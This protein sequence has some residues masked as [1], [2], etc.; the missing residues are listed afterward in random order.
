MRLSVAFGLMLLLVEPFVFGQP[1]D[2]L[3]KG[4]VAERSI[5]ASTSVESF[6]PVGNLRIWQFFAKQTTFGQLTSTVTGRR[7][8]DGGPALIVRESLQID[9]AKIGGETQEVVAGESYVTPLGHFAGCDLKIGP[10]ESAERLVMTRSEEDLT[11]FYTRGGQENEISQPWRKENFFWDAH[12]V[13]QLEIFLAM[14][15]LEIGTIIS[16]SIFLPQSLMRAP[17]VGEVVYFMWQE[18]YKGKFDSVFVIR[19]TEPSEYQLFFTADKRLVRVAMVE[20]GIR[21]YQDVVRQTAVEASSEPVTSYRA[22]FSL[23]ALVFKLPHYF[24][25]VV[26]VALSVLLLAARAFRWPASYLSLFA[27]I[28]LYVVMSLAINP[29]LIWMARHWV[30]LQT[31]SGSSFYL[32]GMVLPLFTGLIQAGLMYSGLFFVGRLSDVR[33]YQWCGLGAFLGGAF[34]L[35]ESIYI[36]GWQIEILFNWPLLERTVMI[37]MHTVSGALI[38]RFMSGERLYLAWAIL[39]AALVNGSVRYLPLLVQTRKIGLEAVHLVMAIGMVLYLLAVVVLSKR[40]LSRPLERVA[41]EEPT[42]Q[43]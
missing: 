13:D 32:V 9:F 11:G 42:D 14:R 34:G 4:A 16:D 43:D 23:R 19:L 10:P 30:N 20:Q 1:P 8:I 18:I 27:G 38:G 39:V 37:V 22:P 33:P 26:I 2:T 21:V 41:P 17:I 40:A 29:M 36:S 31:A 25:F 7:E 3:P 28:V 35:A 5:Q 15:D 24:A 12:L 6:R